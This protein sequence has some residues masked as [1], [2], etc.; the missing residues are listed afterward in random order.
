MKRI[1]CRQNKKKKEKKQV[2]HKNVYFA[3][4][5]ETFWDISDLP[6]LR[7]SLASDLYVKKEKKKWKDLYTKR[8]YCKKSKSDKKNECESWQALLYSRRTEGRGKGT[9]KIRQHTAKNTQ[10]REVR[11]ELVP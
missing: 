2:W 4:L 8:K 5:W 11:E 1:K 7:F 9:C 3:L 10:T 6:G